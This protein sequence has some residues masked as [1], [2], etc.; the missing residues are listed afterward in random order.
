VRWVQLC[1]SLSILWHC[2][3]LGLEWKL[4]FSS[5]VATAEFSKF[6]GIL[7][8]YWVQHFHSISG[9][10]TIYYTWSMTF[11]INTGHSANTGLFTARL[12]LFSPFPCS[13]LCR[14]VTLHSPL[15][16]S[17]KLGSPFC[18]VEY[19]Q[20]LFSVV[21]HGKFV[22]SHVLIYSIICLYQYGLYIYFILWVIIQY[23]F[24]L[25]VQLFQLWLLRSLSVGSCI[26]FLPFFFPPSFPPLS[27]FQ[28]FL[29]FWHYKSLLKNNH[30]SFVYSTKIQCELTG[31]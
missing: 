24:I 9:V 31:Y 22:S 10:H 20:N 15:L 17:G 3:S 6:A 12:L 30:Y 1:S 16:R 28:H 19:L 7:L 25:L 2:F 4:T 27:F 11:D 21:L 26:F 14:G 8:A 18:R 13:P 23:Y 29:I 5:P